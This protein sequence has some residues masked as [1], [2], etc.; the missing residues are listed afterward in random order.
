MIKPK[1]NILVHGFFVWYIGRIIKQNFTALNFN[2]PKIEKDKAI[3]LLANHFS[4]WD[5]FLIFYLNHVYFK[6]QFRVMIM[7]NTA[8]KIWF[9]KFL[10]SFSVQPNSRSVLQ[11]LQY[12]GE[13]LDKPENLVLVF[14]QGKLH[15]S[16]IQKV[17]F[18]KGIQKIVN[19]SQKKFQYV[20]SVALT[21]YFEHKKPSL[22]FNF[23]QHSAQDF[24]DLNAI[25]NSFN[26]H[27]QQALKKQIEKVV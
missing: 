11:S 7:E 24:E 19:F 4:W 18:Q 26:Q 23:S 16:H 17:G 2:T 1:K 10:G 6:K 25:E 27:Y 22:Y 15:S 20:F 3:F 13:L 12:A 8:K 5:G 14:P 21:D 9:M